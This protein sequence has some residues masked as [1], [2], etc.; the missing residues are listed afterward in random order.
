MKTA[1]EI[2]NSPG[3]NIESVYALNNWLDAN[4]SIFE[5][6]N[7]EAIHE[8]SEKELKSISMLK[9]PNQVVFLLKIKTHTFSAKEINKTYSLFLD[10][11]KDPGNMGTI[12]RIADWFGIKWV[13]LSDGC[14]EVY[15]PKVVQSSMG[16][17]LRIK[18]VKIPLA[19]I[20]VQAKDLPVLGTKLE[21]QSVFKITMPEAA[22]IVVGNESRGISP[23]NSH[24][25]TQA[26]SIPRHPSGGAES[27][28]AAVATG[29]ICSILRN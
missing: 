9:T 22:V 8:I 29:I 6:L 4:P 19:E 14:V 10:E 26:I 15:N 24:L 13:F 18:T 3:D 7:K 11:I 12:L 27:L 17:F 1:K 21:G 28:N 23:E 16:A 20:V 5:R 25:L 2:M